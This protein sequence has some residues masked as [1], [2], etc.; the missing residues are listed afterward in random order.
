MKSS[1]PASVASSIANSERSD[2]GMACTTV[3]GGRGGGASRRCSTRAVRLRLSTLITTQSATVP[4][5]S[6]STS[7]SPGRIRRTVAAW[8]PSSPSTMAVAPGAG[9]TST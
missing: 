9:M 1:A 4:A 8:N 2:F 3:T 5:P 6:E 7:D